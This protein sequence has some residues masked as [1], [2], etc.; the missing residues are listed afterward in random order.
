[1]Q[2]RSVARGLFPVRLEENGLL[3]S[4]EGTA[5]N[6]ANRFRHLRVYL[7]LPPTAVDNEAALHL[8]YIAQE[9]VL[10]AFNHG[11]ASHVSISLKPDGVQFNLTV[12][13]DGIGFDPASIKSGGM[14]IRIMR[15]RAIVICATLVVKSQPGRGTE[16]TCMFFPTA[17]PMREAING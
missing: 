6:V 15:Y 5:A 3:F 17:E 9:A 11:T 10:N 16:V 14:G 13:D 12:R 2:V 1:M 8:Y 4:L 7:R